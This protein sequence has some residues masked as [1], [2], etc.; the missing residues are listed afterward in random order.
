MVLPFG[1]KVLG[2]E[3]NAPLLRHLSRRYS[4]L[5]GYWEA[6]PSRSP[7]E[8]GP[9]PAL[10]TLPDLITWLW[11]H[12]HSRVPSSTRWVVSGTAVLVNPESEIIFAFAAGSNYALRLP[13]KMRKNAVAAGAQQ[14]I[15]SGASTIDLADIGEEWVFGMG[16][17]DAEEWWDSAFEYSKGS[18]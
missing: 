12:I 10:G 14:K 5:K 15:G 11:E 7:E 9:A 13:E 17:A 16:T 1:I 4:H 2:V 3:A 8:V 18:E 6:N